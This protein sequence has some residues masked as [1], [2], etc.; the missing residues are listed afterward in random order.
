MPT[1]A[2]LAGVGD[3]VPSEVEGGSLQGLLA[4]PESGRVTRRRHEAVFHFPHY[5]KDSLGPVSAIIAGDFK[6]IRVYE[7][8]TRLLFDLSKDIGEQHDL[9]ASLPAKVRELDAQLTE[10]LTAV[11]AGLPTVRSGAGTSSVSNQRSPRS[12]RDSLL[13]ALDQDDDGSLSAKELE[14]VPAVLRSL[15]KDGNDRVSRDE[16]RSR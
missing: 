13:E 6:L 7:T 8:D 16:A 1:I 15:D 11:D 4:N 5:D 14:M 3:K 2:D 10:Y 12:R 9:A